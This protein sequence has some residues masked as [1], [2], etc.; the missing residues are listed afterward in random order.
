MSNQYF[1]N[2]TGLSYFYNR[3]KTIFAKQE[4][5]ETL[6]DRVD[7]IVAEGGEPNVIE[8]V[9]VNNTALVPDVNKAVDISVPT[10]TSD[11]TND[12]DGNNSPFATEAYVTTNGGKIDSIQ[13]NGTAQTITNKT[14]N[15]S[16]P[17]NNNQLTNGAG[18]QTASNVTTTVESYGY[19]TSSDVQS[20]ID[21]RL[22]ST[23]KA[24]G[25]IAF[26]SIPSLTA[27][28][29]GKVYN[30][31]DSF[32]TTSDFVEGAGKSHPAGTNVVII[33]VGNSTYKYDVLAGFVDLSSYYNSTNLAA[34][35]TLEIDNII[36]DE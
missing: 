8:T 3:I 5:L 21:A 28:N 25:S 12:G 13:V 26:A 36:E 33:D 14:V 34:I 35:T 19:Q 23:Y 7:D 15:I 27:A 17:T 4:D 31:S 16:V 9:K 10:S 30:I 20:A 11:L 1:L 29:E 24:A 2:N 32:T 6:E 18:Y 22:S